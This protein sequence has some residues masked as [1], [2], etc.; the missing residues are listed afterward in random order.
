[1]RPVLTTLV[2][3]LRADS[4]LL[5]RRRKHPYIGYWTGLGGKIEP[6]ESPRECAIREVLEESGLRIHK[7]KLRC[8]VTEVSPRPD[9]QWLIFVY[10]ASE[11]DG[12]L[13]AENGAEEVKWWTIGNPELKIPEADNTFF[14]KALASDEPVYEATYVY[15]DSMMLIKIVDQDANLSVI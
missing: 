4:V 11:F 7:P 5:V 12:E 9:W 6:G 13:S 8:I 10:A 2:Y 3:C 14:Y 15:D 1:M